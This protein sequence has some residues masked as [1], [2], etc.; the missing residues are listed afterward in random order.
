MDADV[1]CGNCTFWVGNREGRA[2]SMGDCRRYAPRPGDAHGW[3]RTR[4]DDGCGEFKSEEQVKH[5][6]AQ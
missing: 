3:P 5:D 6:E 4:L 2:T 1:K